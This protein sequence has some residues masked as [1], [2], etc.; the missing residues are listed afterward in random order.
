MTDRNFEGEFTTL[1]NI[2]TDLARCNDIDVPQDDIRYTLRELLIAFPVYRT[3]G[4]AD[5]LTA[6]DVALLNRVVASV[7]AP[8]PALSL[9]VRIL[10]GDLDASSRDAASLFRTR[11][12]QLTGPLMAKSV[13]DTLFFRHNLELALNEVGP[14]PPRARS[15]YPAFTRRC[16]SVWPVSPMRC[17]GPPRTTPSAGKTRGRASTP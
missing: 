3:Y 10:T 13:E 15:R 12:Q 1:L 6:P 11:F 16:A 7:D 5:G 8:E 2:A 4:T 17:W 14:I 9:L